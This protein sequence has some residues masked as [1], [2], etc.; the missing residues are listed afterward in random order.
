MKNFK[1]SMAADPV[2]TRVWLR[3]LMLLCVI[4]IVWSVSTLI[5]KSQE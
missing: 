2:R 3:V 4:G 1:N 5:A